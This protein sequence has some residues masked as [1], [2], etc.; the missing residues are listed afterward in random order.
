MCIL[1]LSAEAEC[2][3]MELQRKL[4]EAKARFHRL[5][6]VLSQEVEERQREEA[7]KRSV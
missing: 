7:R 1:L 2:E 6:G 4:E 5:G 3:V